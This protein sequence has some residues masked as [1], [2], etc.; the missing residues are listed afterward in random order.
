MLSWMFYAIVVSSLISLAALA[1][2]R[3]AQIQGRPTRWLWAVGMVASIAIL[4]IPPRESVQL[5]ATHSGTAISSNTILPPP[6]ATPTETARLT[7]PLI[8]D[9]Q[10]PL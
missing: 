3:S 4:F 10:T 1:F 8:G 7:L 9:D 6:A 2:E 5:P